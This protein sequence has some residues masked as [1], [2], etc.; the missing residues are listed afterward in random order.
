MSQQILYPSNSLAHCLFAPPPSYW[1]D[2][3]RSPFVFWSAWSQTAPPISSTL[4]RQDP[5]S[6]R[7]Q[8]PQP[9]WTRVFS[10]PPPLSH[11]P[12]SP[13]WGEGWPGGG[14]AREGEC[15]GVFSMDIFFGILLHI[16][17]P[18][19]VGVSLIPNIAVRKAEELNNPRNFFFYI[20]LPLPPSSTP[21]RF[22]VPSLK[23]FVQWV[24]EEDSVICRFLPCPSF[25]WRSR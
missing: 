8:A 18:M 24:I 9:R 11:R 3:I 15:A 13:G 23:I 5:D 2:T 22:L 19:F 6:I 21:S 14:E 12:L 20:S 16:F 1:L 17:I 4:R 7:H 25:H 10:R